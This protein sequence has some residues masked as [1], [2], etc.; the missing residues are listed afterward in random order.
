MFINKGEYVR[1]RKNLLMPGERLEG[2]PED[3]RE[4]PLKMWLKGRL[5]Y[6]S[7]LFQPAHI[8][9]ATGRTQF[10]DLKETSPAYKCSYGQYV[11]EI[12][13]MRDI[14]LR[15]MWGKDDE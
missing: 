13:K 4:T 6:E 2:I 15:E 5:C 3:T 8:T 11:D 14:I 7:E 12:L 9:T 10:G 1:I